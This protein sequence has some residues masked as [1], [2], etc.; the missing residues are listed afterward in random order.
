MRWLATVGVGSASLCHHRLQPVR[1][2]TEFWMGRNSPF[3]MRGNMARIFVTGSSCSSAVSRNG[4]HLRPHVS[5]GEHSRCGHLLRQT[6]VHPAAAMQR[7]SHL[8]SQQA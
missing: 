3:T 6:P 8:N 5:N 4:K 2:R 7:R 1:P